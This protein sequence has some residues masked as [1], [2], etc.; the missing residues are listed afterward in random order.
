M[1]ELKPRPAT[2]FIKLILLVTNFSSFAMSAAIL[3]MPSAV[4]SV[5]RKIET[6]NF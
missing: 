3:R 5:G 2:R 1:N 6:D 4:F